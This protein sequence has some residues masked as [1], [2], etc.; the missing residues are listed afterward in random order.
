MADEQRPD[1]S[2]NEQNQGDRS[3]RSW[4]RP[5][6]FINAGLAV[7][8]V[9][10][11]FLFMRQT[12][13]PEIPPENLVVSSVNATGFVYE[14]YLGSGLEE[15]V[16]QTDYAILEAM[17]DQEVETGNLG[18]LSV[19][20]QEHQGQ[21]FHYQEL[22]IPLTHDPNDFLAALDQRLSQRAPAASIR[23]DGPNEYLVSVDGADTHRLL[24]VPPSVPLPPLPK[25]EGRLAIV[26]DD[27]GENLSLA[28]SL[29]RLP[30]P[31]TFAIWPRASQTRAVADLARQKGLEIL[32]HMPMEPRGYPDDDPGPGAL[33]TSMNPDKIRGLV[34]ANL[35]KVP[36]AVGMNN[37]MGSAFTADLAG[38]TAAL[39]PLA[40]R[41][42]FFLDS[43]TTGDS[44]A[45]DAAR[46]TGVVFH[47]RDVFIDNVA[48]VEAVL[49]QLRKA[50]RLALTRGSAIA[51]GHPHDE[52]LRALQLWAASR[53]AN[54]TVVP[55]SRLS[56]E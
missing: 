49:M 1:D 28:R 44:A 35:A 50:E 31:V 30:V 5:V 48:D 27:L 16:K 34:V 53:S 22:R 40:L 37:H 32:V 13:P 11:V 24:L 17:R 20:D 3:G 29:T 7:V 55:V 42:L 43:R 51:I 6:L 54:L 18:L 23:V 14:E 9:L 4:L 39:E 8:L 2:G 46:A 41:G 33:F 52:T 56:P 25:G 10:L 45:K 47:A 38:M 21:R 15:R 26:I 36:G 19:S 12:A